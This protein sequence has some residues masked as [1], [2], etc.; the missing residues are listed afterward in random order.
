MAEPTVAIAVVT[1]LVMK[2]LRSSTVHVANKALAL[3][4]QFQGGPKLGGGIEV[5]SDVARAVN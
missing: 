1:H 4:Q 3:L 2:G 5:I